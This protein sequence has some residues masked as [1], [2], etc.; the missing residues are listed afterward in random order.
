[1][2]NF[3]HSQQVTIKLTP[4]FNN[5]QYFAASHLSSLFPFLLMSIKINPR[6]C[7]IT[8][9]HT[10]QS[11]SE[12]HRPSKNTTMSSSY[13]AILTNVSGYH[14]LPGPC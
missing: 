6:H 5:Q 8:L 1:M 9:L 7:V 10:S 12:K 3:K 2:K 4:R 14:L 11:I 13:L